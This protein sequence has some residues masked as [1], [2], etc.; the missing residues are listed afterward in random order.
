MDKNNLLGNYSIKDITKTVEDLVEVFGEND[1]FVFY[2]KHM[3]NDMTKYQIVLCTKGIK[4]YRIIE[5][6]YF[7]DLN[8]EEAQEREQLL[9]SMFWIYDRKDVLKIVA[10]TMRKTVKV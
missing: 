7:N 6:G 10:T 3:K 5:H 4:G 9:N 8:K 2:Y 1:K